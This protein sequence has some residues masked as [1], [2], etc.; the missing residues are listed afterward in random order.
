MAARLLILA[1]F[2]TLSLSP[3]LASASDDHGASKALV[4]SPRVEARIGD[5]QVVLVY[6]NRR[7]YEDPIF[8]VFGRTQKVKFEAPRLAL[9]V[10]DFSTSIPKTDGVVEA[11]INFLPETLTEIAPGVYASG[12]VTLGGG[13]NEIEIS[14]EF[15]VE[16]GTRTLMLVV[17]GG[18]S[19]GNSAAAASVSEVKPTAVPG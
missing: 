17:P 11:T 12:E 8:K 15:G 2:A 13:R 16:T 19:S 10:E 5:L 1:I 18:E 9:F 14:Y 6:A 7:Q 4:V 3:V